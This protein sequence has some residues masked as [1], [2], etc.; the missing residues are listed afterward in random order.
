MLTEAHEAALATL[1]LTAKGHLFGWSA[2]LPVLAVGHDL[3]AQRGW[4]PALRLN[5]LV[6]LVLVFVLPQVLAR[7]SMRPSR[8]STA[9]ALRLPLSRVDPFDVPNRENTAFVFTLFGG[10]GLGAF[11]AWL[12]FVLVSG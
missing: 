2:L 9:R 7:L 3:A 4:A 6:L 5:P 10:Y 12:L 8:R 1:R 11:L